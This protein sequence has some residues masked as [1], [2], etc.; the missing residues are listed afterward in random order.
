MTEKM[1]MELTKETTNTYRYDAKNDKEAPASKNIYIQK[2]ALPDT[3]P[4]E[5][6]VSIDF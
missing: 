4:E 2:W 5:V 3:P 1:K 6:E